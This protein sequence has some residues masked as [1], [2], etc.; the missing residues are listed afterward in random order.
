VRRL[1]DT[2]LNASRQK[3][4]CK[5][6]DDEEAVFGGMTETSK[7]IGSSPFVKSHDTPSIA[8]LAFPAQ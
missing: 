7:S 1:D 2:A 8:F 4:R 5:A 6:A 3:E